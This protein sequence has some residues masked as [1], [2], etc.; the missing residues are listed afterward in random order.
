MRLPYPDDTDQKE[1]PQLGD[2][3][4]S[5]TERHWHPSAVGI[6]TIATAVLAAVLLIAG[7]DSDTQDKWDIA[8][9]F[10]ASFLYLSIV[11]IMYKVLFPPGNTRALRLKNKRGQISN[12]LYAFIVLVLTGGIVIFTTIISPTI[13][14]YQSNNSTHQ[15][16]QQS[17]EET[18]PLDR[19]E[20]PAEGSINTTGAEESSSEATDPAG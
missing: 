15:D 7:L 10:F 13:E 20:P 4:L 6:I 19:A 16:T 12:L 5:E 8:G 9:A 14:W 1:G 11:V 18:T 17:G 3:E 2:Q